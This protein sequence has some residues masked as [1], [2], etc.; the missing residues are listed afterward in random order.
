L[1]PTRGFHTELEFFRPDHGHQ[2]INEQQQRDNANDHG[3]HLSS[4]NFSQSSVYSAL[5]TK[6]ATITP[7]NIKSLIE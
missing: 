2:Q 3:F 6:N 1:N 5:T 4:Y 7:M